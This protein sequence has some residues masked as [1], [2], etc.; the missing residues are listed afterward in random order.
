MWER[1]KRDGE[2]NKKAL[3]GGGKAFLALSDLSVYEGFSFG[4]ESEAGGEVIFDTEMINAAGSISDRANEGKIQVMAFPLFGCA[5]I[6]KSDLKGPPCISGLVVREWC[7]TPSNFRSQTDVSGFLK[8]HNIPGLCG[9]DTREII[10]KINSS[11]GKIYGVIRRGTPPAVTD[12]IFAGLKE[13]SAYPL[14]KAEYRNVIRTGAPKIGIIDL[15]V[16]DDF[17]NAV[18]AAGAGYEIFPANFSADE[19]IKSGADGVIISNGGMSVTDLHKAKDEICSLIG[20]LPV[21]G[22][23]LGRDILAFALGFEVVYKSG[24]RGDIPVRRKSDGRVFMLK[25]VHGYA[26]DIR[27]SPE[28]VDITFEGVDDKSIEGFEVKGK[29]AYGVGFYPEERVKYLLDEFINEARRFY[30]DR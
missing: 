7:E 10:K 24:R 2:N 20:R 16:S 18:S 29:A 17:L 13:K 5:G 11:N 6:N 14:K 27:K 23:G 30:A 1:Q 4:G 21:F 22:F 8:E 12:D 25:K 26:I 15:G 28:E 19:I 9:V 3:R